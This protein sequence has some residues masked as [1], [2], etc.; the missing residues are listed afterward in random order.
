LIDLMRHGQKLPTGLIK[1]AGK[2]QYLI[3]TCVAV[4]GLGICSLP[5]DA[6]ASSDEIAPADTLE[7]DEQNRVNTEQTPETL[8]PTEYL[9][10]HSQNPTLKSFLTK[11]A[12]WQASMGQYVDSSG[13]RIDLFFGGNQIDVTHKG[14]RID[15]LLPTTFYDNGKITTGLNFRVQIDLPRTN[16]RWKVVLTSYE[17]SLY[18]DQSGQTTSNKPN[19]ASTEISG[20]EDKTTTVATRYMLFAKKNAFSHLDFG[21]KFTDLIDPNPYGR[22]RTRYKSALS[23]KLSSRTTNDVYLERARGGSIETQQVFDYQWQP[24]D[25]LRSQTTGV[26]WHERGDYQLNQK[27]VWYNII[28]P[29]RVHAYYISGNWQIDNENAN[30]T[31]ISVGMNWREKIYKEWLFGEIE[32]KAIWREDNNFKTPDLSLMLQLEMRFYPPN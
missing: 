12:G 14:S 4:L 24:K 28:N 29:H 16:R 2:S 6:S 18:N 30:F 27:G 19:T 26:W 1:K 11:F 17:D 10:Q 13:E 23:E 3:I 15:V 31:D 22:F 9:L 7:A 20:E 5:T 8:Q 32:P 21:L 25:L